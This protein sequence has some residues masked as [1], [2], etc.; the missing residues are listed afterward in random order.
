M[1]N[2]LSEYSD[3]IIASEKWVWYVIPTDR[4]RETKNVTF[5]AF[6]LMENVNWLDIV[7]HESWA[8]SPTL[9]DWDTDVWYMHPGQEDNLMTLSWNRIVELYNPNKK[10]I[11]RFEIS[12]DRILLNGE[13][14]YKGLVVLGWEMW[15][16]HRNH[17][18]EWSI[19]QNFAVR[20]EKFNID[21]EFNIYKLNMETWEYKVAREGKEDQP[22]K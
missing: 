16:F 1:V 19:S 13:L 17:S 18:P 12:Y 21:T 15:V 3:K 4:L 8:N 9:P 7:K 22:L 2:Y 14:L 5:D 10:N 20:D 11:D 6:S